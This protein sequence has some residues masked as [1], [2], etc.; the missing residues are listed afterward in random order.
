M[1]VH[2]EHKVKRENQQDATNLMFII[3]LMSQ[4]VLG[5]IML[6][7]RRIRLCPTACGV[8]HWLCWLWL[9][10]VLWSCVVSHEHCVEVTVRTVTFTQCS[11][12]MMQFHKT[13]ANH[14]LHTQAEHHM[15]Q[16]MVLFS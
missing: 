11:R 3:K 2:C 6:I 15:L 16:Y 10:V 5:I 12:L 14:N 13:T 8:L 1:T 4:H 7:I 9:A